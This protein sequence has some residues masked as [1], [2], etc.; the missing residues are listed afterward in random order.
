MKAAIALLVLG[1]AL[2]SYA[3]TMPQY[4][5]AEAFESRYAELGPSDSSKFLELRREMLTPKFK[6]EDYGVTALLAGIA[7]AIARRIKAHAAPKSHLAFAILA[8]AAP[9]VS[10]AALTFDL[11]QGFDRGEFP[12]WA[13][14]LGIPLMGVPVLIVVG[15]FWSFAHLL[16]LRGSALSI[17]LLRTAVSR[18]SHP[19]LL[20]VSAITVVLILMMVFDGAYW[21]AVPG[22]LWLY[23]YA[24]LA[25]TRRARAGS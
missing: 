11:F 13:D 20:V 10:G 6:L 19:W 8:I 17:K 1:V 5:D 24:S 14:S 18:H 16:F 23:F 12:H 21:F 4:K 25:A 9:L 7:F 22:L 15:L 2:L 3:M